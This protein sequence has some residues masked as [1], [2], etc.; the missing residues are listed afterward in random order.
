MAG[1]GWAVA[2]A[3]PPCP[4]GRWGAAGP[5]LRPGR[6]RERH[7]RAAAAPGG[8][9]GGGEANSAR[10]EPLPPAVA[11]AV[12]ASPLTDRA[13]AEGQ[14]EALELAPE[15]DVAAEPTDGACGAIQGT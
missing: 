10:L 12:G 6:L 5:K 14:A 2:V 7:R 9:A 11:A 8:G 4:A 1:A 15:Q 3:A 13:L